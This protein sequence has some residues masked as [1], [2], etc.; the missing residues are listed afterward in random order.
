MT[1]LESL[2][3]LVILGLSAVGFLE[4]FQTTSRSVREAEAWVQAVGH[5][6]A[7]MEETKLAA[8]AADPTALPPGFSGATAVQPWAGAEGVELVT[9]TVTLPR[10]GTFTLQRLVRAR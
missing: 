3:A 2:V 9:V 1:L 10:G 6:E 7:M 8:G 4:A 5:A